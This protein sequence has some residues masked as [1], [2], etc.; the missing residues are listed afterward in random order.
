MSALARALSAEWL[1]LRGTLAL[2]LCVVAPAVVVAVYVLQMTVVRMPADRPPPAPAEAWLAFA[3]STL[4]LWAF[5]MV[6]LFV[7]LQAALLAGQEH[8]NQQWKHLLALPVPRAVHYLAKLLALAGLLVLAQ[9]AMLAL[10]P[11]GGWLLALLRPGFGIAGP[12]PWGLLLEK[13]ALVTAAS[14]LLVALHT[15]IA[16]R[17]RSFTVA[18]GVGM[19]ATVMGFLIGQ[20]ARFG[21]WFPWSL[22]VQAVAKADPASVVAYSLAGALLA[23]VAGLWAFQRR[24]AD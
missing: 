20:S 24:E 2:W 11:L 9:L 17:W 19:G 13:L 6:P 14:L 10:L 22:P 23:G 12:A 8:A 16:V 15:F 1:K 21:P 7:T 3:Q 4:A 18:V 5:L